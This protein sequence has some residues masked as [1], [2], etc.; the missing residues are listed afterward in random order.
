MKLPH[1]HITA[2]YEVS[3]KLNFLPS[4][5]LKT[6]RC[7]MVKGTFSDKWI[8]ATEYDLLMIK[9]SEQ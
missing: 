9:K 6:C 1:I 7:G 5:E 8:K 4:V 3:P 2:K